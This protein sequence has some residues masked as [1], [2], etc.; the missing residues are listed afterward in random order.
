MRR[1]LRARSGLPGALVAVGIVAIVVPLAVAGQHGTQSGQPALHVIPFPNTPDASTQ[2]QIIFLALKPSD[3]IGK[4]VVIGS[5]SGPHKGRLTSLPDGAG[6]DFV[7][8]KPFAAGETVTVHAA[9]SSA[10]ARDKSGDP[11]SPSLNWSFSIARPP[12]NSDASS[13]GTGGPAAPYAP[14]GVPVGGAL[15]QRRRLSA[16][17]PAATSARR[18]PHMVFRSEPWLHPAAL[19]VTAGPAPGSQD[20]FV[21]PLPGSGRGMM[22]LNRRGQLLWF[23]PVKRGLGSLLAVQRYLGQPVLVYGVG[24]PV[25]GHDVGVVDHILNSSYRTIAEVRAG[26]GYS[27]DL[28]EFQLAPH[29]IALIDSYVPVQTDLSSVGGP[30]DGTVY[31]CV[32]QKIDVKTGKVLW[33]W[34]ALGHVPLTASYSA[35]PA[36]IPFD[37]FHLNSIQQLPGNKLLISSRNTWAVYLIDEN[38]GNIIWSLGGKNSTFTLG[39]GTRFEWQ[40][41]ARLLPGN[42]LTVFD[43]ADYPQEESQSSAKELRVNKSSDT[44]SLVHTYT[45][46]PS[47]LAGY[48]GSAQ[49]LPDDDMVVGWGNVSAFSEYRPDGRQVFNA[50]FSL[51]VNTY[52]ALR[53][54]WIGHP[55]GRPDVT[56]ARSHGTTEV[57]VSWNGATQVASWRVLGGATSQ[58]LTAVASKPWSGFETAIPVHSQVSYVEVQALN[59]SGRVL[60]SSPTVPSHG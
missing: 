5:T 11:G 50:T 7:P 31:D 19:H 29:G 26:W 14:A 40:H 34:H 16:S 58:S 47:L 53:F 22:I 41:D 55:R 3:L 49:L 38:T 6:T 15:T 54:S 48:E 59:S 39:P 32:I 2:S 8:D 17:A 30:T 27:A 33:E 35:V 28:H 24:Q 20:F 52:R 1:L 21:T 4:P 9:L 18:W 43:D 56:V 36:K 23:H 44:V 10:T 42:I 57:Y 51:S 37:F 45:H 46:K 12:A 60:G 25:Q 13:G